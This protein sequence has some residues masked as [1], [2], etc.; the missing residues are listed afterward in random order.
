MAFD[1]GN[2]GKDQFGFDGFNVALRVNLLGYVLYVRIAEKTNH[3]T[4]GVRFANIR[5]EFVAQTFALRSTGNQACNINEFHRCRDDLRRMVDGSKAVKALIGNG[6]QANI[7]LDGCKRIVCSKSAL[8]R[9]GGEQRRLANV[10]QANNA[11]GKG[12]VCSLI[13]FSFC[14]HSIIPPKR[15]TP[16]R[17][18]SRAATTAGNIGA[19]PVFPIFGTGTVF[20]SQECHAKKPCLRN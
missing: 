10:R 14:M 17:G 18:I 15:K 11:N 4:D 5:Q 9:K 6:N 8:L 20:P 12:H 3:F 13:G 1:G 7:G 2:I 16:E 19:G